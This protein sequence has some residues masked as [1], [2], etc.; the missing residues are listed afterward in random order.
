MSVEPFSQ[1]LIPE[2]LSKVR[3]ARMVDAGELTILVE[4]TAASTTTR[5]AQAAGAGVDA[6]SPDRRC[7]APMTWRRGGCGTTATGRCRL[8]HLSL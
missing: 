1:R 3:A 2:V 8:T 6:L 5:L 7:T 4:T